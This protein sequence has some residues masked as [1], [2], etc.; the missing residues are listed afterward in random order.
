MGKRGREGRDRALSIK[1]AGK[2]PLF[3]RTIRYF[4]SRAG[5]LSICLG[6]FDLGQIPL[7]DTHSYFTLPVHDKKEW[8]LVCTE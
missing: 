1:L 4:F 5:E 7:S 3:L 8:Q 2:E 6:Y